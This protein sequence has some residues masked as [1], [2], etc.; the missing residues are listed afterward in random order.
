[1]GLKFKKL[2]R[3]NVRKLEQD[4]TITEHGRRDSGARSGYNKTRAGAH[5]STQSACRVL[6]VGAPLALQLR[7][8][9]PAHESPPS[10][11]LSRCPGA[12]RARIAVS[13]FELT[14]RSRRTDPCRA[15]ELYRA[16]RRHAGAGRD[17]PG[18]AAVGQLDRHRRSHC[19]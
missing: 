17:L 13:R 6:T 15:M 18:S 8:G 4:K 14:G 10:A 2:T 19:T 3:P 12:D 16:R 11:T 1:M 5:G 9:R 7:R